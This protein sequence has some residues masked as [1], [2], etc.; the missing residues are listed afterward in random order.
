MCGRCYISH[1]GEVLLSVSSAYHIHL[2][3][4]MHFESCA[5]SHDYQSKRYENVMIRPS[6]IQTS[7][8]SRVKLG[9]HIV[10]LSMSYLIQNLSMMICILVYVL[11]S[12]NICTQLSCLW[13][14]YEPPHV[15]WTLCQQNCVLSF[16]LQYFVCIQLYICMFLCSP[17]EICITTTPYLTLL[18]P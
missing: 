16:S 18:F 8:P 11:T 1:I 6:C 3:R 13:P 2:L 10:L 9:M 12:I 4:K 5:S 17:N 14:I 7:N 15:I